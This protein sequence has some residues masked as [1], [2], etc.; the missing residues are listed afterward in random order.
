MCVYI[1]AVQVTEKMARSLAGQPFA[2][3]ANG[4]GIG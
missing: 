2:Q 3:P 4:F 1:I